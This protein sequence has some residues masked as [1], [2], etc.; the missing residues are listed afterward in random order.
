MKETKQLTITVNERDLKDFEEVAKASN[1]KPE[2][3]L[4]E[5]VRETAETSRFLKLIKEI[6]ETK[7]V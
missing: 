2:E 6:R 5:L 7:G 3:V 1:K 4:Q